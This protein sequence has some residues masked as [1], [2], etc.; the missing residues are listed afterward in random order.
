M[1]SVE[2]MFKG[3]E[4]PKKDCAEHVYFPGFSH[5]NKKF[6]S[7]KTQTKHTLIHNTVGGLSTVFQSIK[8]H[9]YTQST[10][11]ITTICLYKRGEQICN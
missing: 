3:C 6:V 8:A 2:M 10:V 4:E 11:P 1:F 5:S 7:L 9:L